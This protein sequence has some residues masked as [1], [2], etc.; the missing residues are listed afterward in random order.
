M[1]P[2][3]L[4]FLTIKSLYGRAIHKLA[5]AYCNENLRRINVQETL[6]FNRRCKRNDI[7]PPSLIQKPLFVDLKDLELRGKMEKNIFNVTYKMV[8]VNYAGATGS[9][10]NKDLNY[11]I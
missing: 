7:L 9:S 1:I 10:I 11:Q 5:D 8:S 2:R 3:I 6:N 4:I